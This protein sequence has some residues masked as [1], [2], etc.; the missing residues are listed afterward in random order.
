MV[1]RNNSE[2]LTLNTRPAVVASCKLQ[3]AWDEVESAT[4]NYV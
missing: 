3:V 4:R 1:K 2:P